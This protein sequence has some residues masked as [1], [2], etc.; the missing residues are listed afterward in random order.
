MGFS[1]MVQNSTNP[2]FWVHW[3][4]W[5]T[6]GVMASI[7]GSAGGPYRQWTCCGWC[8]GGTRRYMACGPVA[9]RSY[10][11]GG[12]NTP[13]GI[14]HWRGNS[15]SLGSGVCPYGRISAQT[16]WMDGSLGRVF[17][18]SWWSPVPQLTTKRQVLVGR[19]WS[20]P[21]DSSLHL[22]GS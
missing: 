22:P 4:S 8:V 20:Q 5:L 14:S 2:D 18:S 21:L 15:N 9:W 3:G 11:F 19:G 6:L 7:W 1:G 12:V 17:V 13:V 16:T 10:G